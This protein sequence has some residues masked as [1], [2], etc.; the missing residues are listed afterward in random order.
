MV[1]TAEALISAADRP[2][3]AQQIADTARTQLRM[4]IIGAL[5]WRSRPSE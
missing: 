4:V 3:L 5:Q 1:S 2:A